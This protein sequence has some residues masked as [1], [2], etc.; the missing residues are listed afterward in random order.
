MISQTLTNRM[1]ALKIGMSKYRNIFKNK[2][3]NKE[4]LT[5][6]FHEIVISPLKQHFRY[7]DI[8]FMMG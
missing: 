1:N 2:T 5:E 4:V 8:V 3:W 6:Y 7:I